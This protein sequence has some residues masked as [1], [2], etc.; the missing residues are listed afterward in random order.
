MQLCWTVLAPVTQA[1]KN[2]RESVVQFIQVVLDL[3]KW[4]PTRAVA[5]PACF[6]AEDDWPEAADL[7]HA[8]L[9]GQTTPR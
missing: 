2:A 3:L 9:P 8:L 5:L 7:L 4:N 6:E 1:R